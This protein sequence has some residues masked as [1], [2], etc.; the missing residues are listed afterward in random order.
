MRIHTSEVPCSE[1]AIRLS[2]GSPPSSDPSNGVSHMGRV[3]VCVGG[4]YGSVSS[5]GFGEREGAAVCQQL[6]LLGKG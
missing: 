2:G 3:E 1:N 5:E 4:I 6:G